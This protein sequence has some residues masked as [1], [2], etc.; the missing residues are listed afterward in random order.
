[1]AGYSEGWAKH[2]DPM[3][4]IERIAMITPLRNTFTMMTKDHVECCRLECANSEIGNAM[5]MLMLMPLLTLRNSSLITHDFVNW[6]IHP[7]F[8]PS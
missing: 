3:H 7:S 6:G 8:Y 5:L 1:M 4:M 2:R